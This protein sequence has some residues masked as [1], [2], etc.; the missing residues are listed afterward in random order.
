VAAAVLGALSLASAS[1]AEASTRALSLASDASTVFSSRAPD[2]ALGTGV[3]PAGDVNGDGNLDLLIGAPASGH[4]GRPGSGSAYVVFGSPSFAPRLPLQPLG[5]HGFRIDGAPPEVKTSR[6]SIFPGERGPLTD[7]AGS[8]LAGIGDVNGDGLADLAVSAPYSSP[9]RRVAAGS[10]YVVFG[11]RS[12]D[13]VDLARLGTGGY[14]IVGERKA[15]NAGFTLAATGDANGDGRGDLLVGSF[16]GAS[17]AHDVRTM[18]LVFLRPSPGP[19]PIDLAHLGGSGIGIRGS[20][21]TGP[22]IAALGDMNGD[23]LADVI[24]GSPPMRKNGEGRA[25]VI[26]GRAAAGEL[27]LR[28]LGS[29][30]YTLRDSGNN[31][32]GGNL[33]GLVGG[34]G[35]VNGDGR[36]D[37]LVGGGD[38]THLVFGDRSGKRIDLAHAAGRSIRITGTDLGGVAG[39]VGD[40]N[41]DGLD[42]V[43]FGDPYG[44][45]R[46]QLSSGA[47]TVVYGR[48]T[49]GAV[50]LANLAT[51][52]Y[53]IDGAAPYDMAGNGVDWAGD[54]NRDGRSDVLIGAPRAGA[55]GRAYLVTGRAGGVPRPPGGACIRVMVAP[56]RL[57]HVARTRR[58]RVT[59]VSRSTGDVF[60][61]ARVKHH[62]VV[63]VGG[64]TFRRPGKRSVRLK[65]IN[66]ARAL[67]ATRDHLRVRVI[68]RDFPFS[69]PRSI[70]VALLRR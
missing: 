1:A 25:A 15:E 60:V 46:C 39:S 69:A 62:G 65:L 36:P 67:F 49:P 5:D 44:V 10:V 27:R 6:G 54:L 35:D 30:G 24:V 12:T 31:D 45:P 40:A 48:A 34:P 3:A 59:V 17:Y 50:N 41:G 2:H 58:L 47:V 61:T 52:G 37:I 13:P 68:A 66:H 4:N 55:H 38:L 21:A 43:L 14:R 32:F 57:R 20:W 8:A 19:R 29:A 28:S 53:R 70:A 51:G 11:K 33:G 23:Q 9:K 26:F 22:Y 63:A 16:F 7:G 18:Y 56:Q 42:D 64:A